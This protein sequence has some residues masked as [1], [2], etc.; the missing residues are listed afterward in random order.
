MGQIKRSASFVVAAAL[1]AWCWASPSAAQVGVAELDENCLVSILNRTAIPQPDGSYILPNT[2]SNIGRVRARATCVENGVTRSGQSDYLEFNPLSRAVLVPPIVFGQTEP[3]PD[4]LVI[5][6]PATTLGTV[7]ATAQLTVTAVFPGST[8]DVTTAASGT[9][10]TT[11]NPAV[12]T[13]GSDGLLTAHGVGIVLVSA[14][15]EGALAVLRLQVS[16]TGD[17]DGDGI[18]DDLELANGLDPGNPIDGIDDL[19][20]DELTNRDELMDLGTDPRNPD[21]DGDRLRDSAEGLFGTNPLLYDTDGDQVGDG[22]EVVAGSNPL[23]ANSVDLG[24]IVDALTVQP[25]SF[26]LI[27]N[28]AVGE[29]SRRLTVTASLID[30]TEIDVRSQ[31][32]GTSY[33]SSNLAIVN[34]GAEDGVVF[35]GQDGTATVTVSL[36]AVSDSTQV[37]VETFA[38]TALSFLLLPGFANGVAVDGDFAYVAAGTAGLHVV[39]VSNLNAPVL[40]AT[41]NTPGN[42]NDVRVAA[43]YAYVADG[44]SGLQIVDVNNP[45]APVLIAGFDTPGTATDVAVLNGRAYVA[46]G[47]AGL[48]V[49][50]VSLPV[51]PLAVGA[52]DTPGNARGVDAVDDFAV[53]AD[54]HGGV[55]IVSVAN[56]AS[57]V[58]RG[59]AHMR[60]NSVSRAADVVVRD[61]FAY[62]ADGSDAALGGLRV[63]DFRNPLTPVVVGSTSNQFGL[64]SVALDERFAL[65]ADYFFP[66]AVPIFDVG[67]APVFSAV[68]NFAGAPSFRDDDGNGV[69]VRNGVV[70]LAGAQGITDNGSFGNGGLH[71]GRAYIL[72]DDLGVAPQVAITAPANGASVP[73]RSL[74]TLKAT[75]TDDVLV[76][77]VRF[78]VNG[79]VVAE[80]FKTPF[81]ATFT[82]PAGVTSL[83]LGAIA[84]DLGDNQ[85]TAQPVTVTVVADNKPVVSLIAPVAGARIVEGTSISIAAEASDDIQVTKVEFFV[86]GTLRQTV[87]VAPY[88]FNFTVPLNTTQ[89]SIVAVATDSIGQTASTPALVLP[90]EDD[91]APVVTLLEPLNGAQVIANSRV[92][93]VAGASDDGTVQRVRFL[94]NGAFLGEDFLTPFESE[95]R[96]PATGVTM[97]ISAIA[98]DNLG[99][100]SQASVQIVGIPDPGTTVTGTV[101]LPD[102]QPAAGASVVAATRSSATDAAGRFLIADVPTVD[103]I[104]VRATLQAPGTFLVGF[105]TEGNP[106]LGGVTE[107]GEIQLLPGF[108]N[109][110]GGFELGNFTGYTTT[111]QATVIQ[112]LGPVLPTEGQFMALITT[113]GAAVSGVRSTVNTSFAVPAGATFVA[114]DFNFLS[115]EFPTFVGSIFNDT[116]RVQLTT[117]GGSQNTVIASVNGSSFVQ[118]GGTGFNGMTGFATVRL[119]VSSFAGQP[120]IANLVIDIQ[121][122]DVGDTSVDSAALVDNFRFE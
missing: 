39:D 21:T 65:T 102:G 96:G 114:F 49:I 105:S 86:S 62:V 4:S 38:P 106:V 33:S 47:V 87:T 2:P 48:R 12:A 25:A 120:G 30:G 36:G 119:D 108:P 118:A 18:P 100:Q 66:N 90:V 19:D 74:L 16:T 107:V 58:I 78:L 60:A 99:Q 111:G 20:G 97:T 85:G 76:T 5:S 40:A 14:V 44:A 122:T 43:G 109:G 72:G 1:A 103:P 75:A 35:A 32:Y 8:R 31:R 9:N 101:L 28:T 59:S 41:V 112:T 27:F 117:P 54:A 17:S 11:S 24:P 29:A 104:R 89:I 69:A 82:V 26:T 57:P 91:L 63:V 56:P 92:K 15:N 70:F 45:L 81:Q 13:I 52:V 3:I 115:N 55:H 80:D 94:V 73:E 84:T 37:H 50:D 113:G 95:V 6:S 53:V 121:V 22:L 83:T 23:D 51:A 10:Y 46:D 67:G 110:N 42:A 77:A 116:L 68:L 64:V 98:E 71:I 79:A 93:I 61:R 7:G 34:F 88:R